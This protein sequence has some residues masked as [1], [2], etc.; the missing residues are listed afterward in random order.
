M[1][2]K[3]LIYRKVVKLVKDAQDAKSN[4]Q[5]LADKAAQHNA[6]INVSVTE[7]QSNNPDWKQ[8]IFNDKIH[9]INSYLDVLLSTISSYSRTKYSKE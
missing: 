8:N 4:T 3:I 5:L 6:E 7:A 1:A 9:V 2:Q